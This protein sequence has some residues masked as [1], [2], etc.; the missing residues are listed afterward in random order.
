MSIVNL[1]VFIVMP[2]VTFNAP[3]I[4]ALFVIAV[5]PNAFNVIPPAFDTI[6]IEVTVFP[7]S[8]CINILSSV[9]P[10]V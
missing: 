10:F 2:F 7:C 6:L 3:P 1:S 4:D 5:D 8:D 9:P